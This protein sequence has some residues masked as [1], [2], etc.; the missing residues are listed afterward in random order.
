LFRLAAQPPGVV[1]SQGYQMTCISWPAGVAGAD[2]YGH[3]APGERPASGER[4][5]PGD[6]ATDTVPVERVRDRARVQGLQPRDGIAH[7]PTMV[8]SPG[9]T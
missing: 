1:K 3:R 4:A 2:A 8:F 5:Q 6:H 7:A 9:N